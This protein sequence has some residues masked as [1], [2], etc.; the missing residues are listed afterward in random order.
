MAARIFDFDGTFFRGMKS[1]GDPGQTP[2]GY[3]WSGVNVLNVGGTVGCRPGMR[4]IINFPQG[5]LQGATL[6]RPRLGLEQL[7]VAIDGI[8]Y[9]SPY[10]FKVF[11]QLEGVRMS[12]FAKQM[13]W[14]QAEQSAQRLT[15]NDIESAIEII[16]PRNV[17]FIQDGGAT[18]PIAYDGT[19]ARHIRDNL[20]ET[21][22]GSAMKWIGDRL[23]VAV[24]PLVFASDI[25]NPFSFREQLYLGGTAAFTFPGD[26]TGMA[27]TPSL[28]FPQLLIFTESTTSLM[29]SDIRERARWIQTDGFQKQIFAVGSVGQRCI[30]GHYGQ[31]MWYSASGIVFFDAAALSKQQSRLP[32][33][34]GEMTVSKTTLADDMSLVAGGAFGQYL[35]EAVPAEGLFNLH[36]HV[37]NAASYQTLIDDS[38]P[39]WASVWIGTRPVEWVYGVIAGTEQCYHVSADE[40]GENRLWK[41]FLPERLDNECPITWAVQTRGYFGA[42]SQQKPPGL[43][44]RYCWAEVAFTAVA[45]DTDL[46]ISYAGGLRGAFKRLLTKTLRIARGSFHSP[47]LITPETKIF[48]FKPQSRILRTEEVRLLPNDTE[49]GSC[50]VERDIHEQQDESFQLL[51]VGQGPAT[52]RWIRAFAQPEPENQSASGTACQNEEG[53]NAL[54]FDGAGSHGDNW[55]QVDAALQAR[56]LIAYESNQTASV[57]QDGLTV[58]GVGHADSIISQE[59]A[60]RVAL[61]VATKAAESELERSLPPIFSLGQGF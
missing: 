27:A 20:Y 33:R 9:V 2:L 13:F 30:V 6:F 40:D 57:S 54:R 60:D 49:T 61:I 37:L 15:P 46:A 55:Q 44:A 5:K 58:V 23:W 50:P 28:E 11:R 42:T 31:L 4:C 34:D 59:T 10:P 22:A 41:C 43:D 48:A 35:L 32:L 18:A 16:P 25:G 24:G 7:V 19:T 21:P 36:T 1:D 3:Y 8:I 51:I 38:G 12:S 14:A 45:Q 17:L 39:S 26:V 56:P 29:Q 52:I 47:D 53:D